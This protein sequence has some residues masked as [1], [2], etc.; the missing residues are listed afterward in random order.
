MRYFKI[1]PS[2]RR[3]SIVI[4]L[5]N[6]R[7]FCYLESFANNLSKESEF[8][9]NALLQHSGGLRIL[10]NYK[11]KGSW[12][13]EAYLFAHSAGL[14]TKLQGCFVD[15]ILRDFQQITSK[16]IPRGSSIQTLPPTPIHH[17]S[18]PRDS[19]SVS[20]FTGI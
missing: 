10:K 3:L 15:S 8:S 11:L 12:S 4:L 5:R 18:T 20:C 16:R 1:Q 2:F 13:L 17:P 9:R 19:I 6:P 7:N 14:S